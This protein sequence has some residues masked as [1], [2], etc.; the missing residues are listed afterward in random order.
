MKA[1]DGAPVYVLD[2][3]STD[4]TVSL[5]KQHGAN[6]EQQVITPWRFDTARNVALEMVPSNSRCLCFVGHG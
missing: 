1:A 6:V 3:G 2:T 5:L 4:D